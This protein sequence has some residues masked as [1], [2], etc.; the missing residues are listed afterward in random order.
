MCHAVFELLGSE[1]LSN[2]YYRE[3][4]V[5]ELGELSLAPRVFFAVEFVGTVS[6][7]LL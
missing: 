2:I 6:R 4:I 7:C 1:G 5:V 3:R